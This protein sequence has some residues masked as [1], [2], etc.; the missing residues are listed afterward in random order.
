MVFYIIMKFHWIYHG[1]NGIPVGGWVNVLSYIWRWTESLCVFPAYLF[2]T[3]S[4]A[5]SISAWV[6]STYLSS[7]HIESDLSLSAVPSIQVFL[8][9]LATVRP[10]LY[11][12]TY[13]A[14]LYFL[15]FNAYNFNNV[16][17]F[18]LNESSAKLGQIL[19]MLSCYYWHLFEFSSLATKHVLY[20]A[21]VLWQNLGISWAVNP[22]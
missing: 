19:I 4:L 14:S 12:D 3:L 11:E 17:F 13:M 7:I 5:W 2:W 16:N 21:I 22:I 1:Y 9:T 20:V 10:L 6:I 15:L 18:F 8:G